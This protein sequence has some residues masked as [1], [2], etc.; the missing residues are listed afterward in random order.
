MQLVGLGAFSR[1]VTEKD[2]VK[3]GGF[4]STTSLG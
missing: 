2:A 4:K 3:K 1:S